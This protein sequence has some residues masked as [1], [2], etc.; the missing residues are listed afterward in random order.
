VRPAQK[1]AVTGNETLFFD[2][3]ASDAAAEII[4]V[5]VGPAAVIVDDRRRVRR[6]ALQQFGGGIQ[7][8]RILDVGQVEAEFRKLVRWRQPILDETV[9][10]SGTTAVASIST[11]ASRSTSRTTSTS[12]MAG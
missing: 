3:K 10:H 11:L 12:A 6:P 5:G 9:P 7:E 2:Q 4:E 1:H 8:L